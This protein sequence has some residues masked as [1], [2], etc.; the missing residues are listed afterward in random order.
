MVIAVLLRS[1][2]DLVYLNSIGVAEWCLMPALLTGHRVV[3]H[4]RGAGNRGAR[5]LLLRLFG[6]AVEMIFNSRYS[7][8][9]V[10]EATGGVAWRAAKV[11]YNPVDLGRF[12]PL[13][14]AS[15]KRVR[16]DVGVG[17]E[18]FAVTIAGR[19]CAWKHHE[20]VLQALHILGE[21]D[22]RL[23]IVGTANGPTERAFLHDLKKLCGQMDLK[24]VVHFLGFR[25]DVQH[26]MAASD[27][28]VLPS[29]G[30]P[31]GRVVIEAAACGTPVIAARSGGIPEIFEHG[32]P[33]WLFEPLDAHALSQRIAE[34][35]RD[36]EKLMS[37]SKSARRVAAEFSMARYRQRFLACLGKSSS[38]KRASSVA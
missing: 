13:P 31:F 26:I 29:V 12:R 15:V 22:I 3:I 20:T 32:P 33:G 11:I 2:F 1:R 16:Q 35:R 30:E 28:L 27:V 36:K 38:R 37:L 4:C 6:P 34:A 10:T 5:K 24:K 23:L 17:E 19:I 21:N 14:A 9:A 7:A 18:H 8:R 25:D